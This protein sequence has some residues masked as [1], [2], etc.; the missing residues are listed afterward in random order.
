MVVVVEEEDMN[1]GDAT[2]GT[3]ICFWLFIITFS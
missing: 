2:E 3:V 1:S